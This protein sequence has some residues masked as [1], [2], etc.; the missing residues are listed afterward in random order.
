MPLLFLLN[1]I[2]N[3]KLEVER[4]NKWRQ[5]SGNFYHSEDYFTNPIGNDVFCTARNATCSGSLCNRC[6]CGHEDKTFLSYQ[7][8]CLSYA[9]ISK[10][11]KGKNI[12]LIMPY[13]L[14]K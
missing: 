13:N 9:S 7:H 6:Y 8:G 1:D 10:K 11:L 14:Q 4:D 12:S 5:T 2:L 3:V